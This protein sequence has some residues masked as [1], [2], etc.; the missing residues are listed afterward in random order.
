LFAAFGRGP[1]SDHLLRGTAIKPFPTLTMDFPAPVPA[2]HELDTDAPDAAAAEQ[3]VRSYHNRLG[4]PPSL[5]ELRAALGL[6]PDEPIVFQAPE[7]AAYAPPSQ[8]ASSTAAEEVIRSYRNRLGRPPSMDELRAAV[9][10]EPGGQGTDAEPSSE[11]DVGWGLIGA[12]QARAP[13]PRTPRPPVALPMPSPGGGGFAPPASREEPS[14]SSLPPEPP[15]PWHRWQTVPEALARSLHLGLSLPEIAG[16]R[17]V[18]WLRGEEINDAYGKWLKDRTDAA[19]RAQAQAWDYW[20]SDRDRS[21]Q[22]YTKE[23][24]DLGPCRYSDKLDPN[25]PCYYAG[26]T[27]NVFEP[28]RNV[29]IRNAAR[30]PSDRYKAPRLDCS[31]SSLMAA[32]GRE[33]KLIDYHRDKSVS[34]NLID[35]VGASPWRRYF[36]EMAEQQCGNI[37]LPP[38]NRR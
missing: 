37:P 1:F 13:I 26:H 31:T 6:E 3:V 21:Y 15:A 12:A 17:M 25:S 16:R 4:R 10:L 8:P 30:Y 20:R 35:A 28:A 33:Q 27:G 29:D 38:I 24:E 18:E 9:G 32:R 19:L 23:R 34:D 5:D 7:P 36:E 11:G 2:A 22:T 14:Q